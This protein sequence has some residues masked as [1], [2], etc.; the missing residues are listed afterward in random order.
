MG[1]PGKGCGF[2][3][4]PPVHTQAAFGKL[5]LIAGDGP[6]LLAKGLRIPRARAPPEIAALA[7]ERG[8]RLRQAH[9]YE[10]APLERGVD[11]LVDPARGS[12][13][14]RFSVR[15]KR[16]APPPAHSSSTTNPSGRARNRGRARPQRE[17]AH[18]GASAPGV[19]LPFP[20]AGGGLLL[21]GASSLTC[22]NTLG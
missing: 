18:P 9:Q 3:K 13:A 22:L 1:V 17:E 5:H 10:R 16:L 11:P 2:R 14:V 19:G 20:C 7:G 4:K 6:D 8:P 12:E 15:P 21:W